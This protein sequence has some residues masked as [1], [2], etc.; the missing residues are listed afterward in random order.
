MSANSFKGEFMQIIVD[1]LALLGFFFLAVALLLVVLMVR[2]IFKVVDFLEIDKFSTLGSFFNRED[3][4]FRLAQAYQQS[5]LLL[6]WE[7]VRYVE[8]DLD[9]DLCEELIPDEAVHQANGFN[10]LSCHSN[11]ASFEFLSPIADDELRVGVYR[12]M[13]KAPPPDIYEHC[14]NLKFVEVWLLPSNTESADSS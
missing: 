11:Q 8:N 13:L 1:V 7:V 5:K 14:R 4:A 12:M 10:L 3:Y 2:R 6:F 9:P